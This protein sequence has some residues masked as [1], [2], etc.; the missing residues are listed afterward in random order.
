MVMNTKQSLPSHSSE[1]GDMGG[2]GRGGGQSQW[3]RHR[4]PLEEHRAGPRCLEAEG[5][6]HTSRVGTATIPVELDNST[7]V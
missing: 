4:E 7:G 2:V 5:T 6:S 1:T 3:E